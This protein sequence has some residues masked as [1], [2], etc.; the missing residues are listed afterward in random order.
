MT[1][2]TTGPLG[3]NAEPS[4]KKDE[5]F[6]IVDPTAVPNPQ[7]LDED[8]KRGTRTHELVVDGLPRPFRFEYGKSQEVPVELAVK[9]LKAGFK[10]VDEKG[11]L[12]A[13]EGPPKQPDELQ[14]GETL[15]LKTNETIARFEELSSHALQHRVMILPGGEVFAKSS[16]RRAMVN[17]IVAHKEKLASINKAAPEGGFT[18]EAEAD[19]DLIAA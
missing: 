4:K 3:A 15:K 6:F 9:F 7:A 1:D 16:D 19:D 11:N 13:Y 2:P 8:G 5:K 12:I 18:P 14:A 10:R 17:F